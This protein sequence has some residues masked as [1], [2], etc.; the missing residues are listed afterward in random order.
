M[1]QTLLTALLAG[2][3]AGAVLAGGATEEPATSAEPAAAGAPAGKYR[4]AP[5]LAQRVAA[6][7]LPPVDQRLPDNP[8]VV[9]EEMLVDGVGK[10][11][12]TWRVSRVQVRWIV[13]LR[14]TGS[15]LWI[16]RH[17]YDADVY[18][19]LAAGWEHSA[20]GS[21]W[22]V[23]LRSGT[24]W[25]DGHPMT[26]DD[27]LFW[28][29]DVILNQEL[30]PSIPTYMKVGG[31]P[32]TLVK[33]DDT[34]V[35]FEFPS[36]HPMIP[37]NGAL[38]WLPTRFPKHYFMQ[39]H[40]GHT[41]ADT[42]AD[43]A[44]QEG[45]EEW[46]QLFMDKADLLYQKNEDVPT[47]EPW[48]VERGVPE[49]PVIYRRNPY[50][51]AVD[52]AGQQLP[53]FDELHFD[54]HDREV[55][56]LKVMGGEVDWTIPSFPLENYPLLK[57]AEAEG[58]IKVFFWGESELNAGEINYNLTH[59]DPVLREMFRDKRF[60]IATSYALN[61][62]EINDLVF[63]GL[64]E[65]WQV[66]P[67]TTSRYYHER[68]A[69]QHLEYDPERANQLL[70]EMG[71]SKRDAKGFRLRPDGQP[72]HI[73]ILVT[74]AWGHTIKIAELSVDYLKAVGVSASFN[75]MDIA[76]LR[77]KTRDLN[78]HDAVIGNSWGTNEGVY[79]SGEAAN[80]VPV[81]D[82]QFY[83]PPWFRWYLSGGSD[84]EE[85]VAEMVEAIDYF[86]QFQ[87][88]LDPDEQHRL[89][90]KVLDIAADNLWTIGTIRVPGQLRAVS[91]RTRNV[92]MNP[93]G[94]WRGDRG[95]YDTWYFE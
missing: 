75:S 1:R 29:E 22:T 39:F 86:N 21:A 52:S 48:K 54:A 11:G 69:T 61:R 8:L 13:G 78:E 60:R 65:P 92:P 42:L 16:A 68:L 27:L 12:G 83:A 17:D 5:L 47:L 10:Y 14:D 76:A 6:G 15:G 70:D 53:Y 90:S 64:G 31:D 66:A 89:F 73:V 55:L 2:A 33:V 20:D 77:T 80:F 32:G 72:L 84:G 93:V 59:Q 28:Y 37:Y 95:R 25:S 30:N 41:E 57:E 4:E 58:N 38:N 74:S 23:R 56:N 50:F 63:L 46:T 24:K 85:P 62:E 26:A 19:Q 94:W 3:L 44:K 36:P 71:L 82:T 43:T 34:T 9:T 79:I 7:E 51:Y 87:K 49:I 45:F 91:A 40:P 35:R 18:P 88:E 67:Y 81:R